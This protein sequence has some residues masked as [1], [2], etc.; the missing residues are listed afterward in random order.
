MTGDA[1]YAKQD[2]L[3]ATDAAR[4]MGVSRTAFYR[5]IRQKELKSHE[6]GGHKRYRV[7]DLDKL[8]AQKRG[9][10]QEALPGE[11]GRLTK[12]QAEAEKALMNHELD[13]LVQA[14]IE[15]LKKF[16]IDLTAP[17]EKNQENIRKAL[18]YLMWKYNMIPHYFALTRQ[19]SIPG[20]MKIMG[21][22]FDR[23]LPKQS[24]NKTQVTPSTAMETLV[25][26][27]NTI[28]SRI[29]KLA[30]GQPRVVIEGEYKEVESEFCPPLEI[31]DLRHDE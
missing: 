2:L 20:R 24:N 23:V 3:L 9:T 4:Y 19:E 26:E 10:Q 14:D 17:E 13:Q 31:E 30:N 15:E 7:A 5:Y 8:V 11:R 12:E 29:E 22:L 16:N 21:D 25:E 27:M 1:K 28:T 6:I 18:M